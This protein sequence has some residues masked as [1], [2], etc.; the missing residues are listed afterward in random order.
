MY[1]ITRFLRNGT[2]ELTGKTGESVEVSA[3][4]GSLSAAVLSFPALAQLL[5]LHAKQHE[6]ANGGAAIQKKTASP[7]SE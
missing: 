4:N 1:T 6:K 3:S 5:R 2:C 7:S